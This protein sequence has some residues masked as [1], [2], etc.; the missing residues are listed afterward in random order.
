MCFSSTPEAPPIP[1]A[2]PDP[3]TEVDQGVKDARASARRK[4]MGAAGYSSTILTGAMGD[5]SSAN[6]TGGKALLGQ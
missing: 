3:P 2:P 1:A 6:T 5:T 4:A